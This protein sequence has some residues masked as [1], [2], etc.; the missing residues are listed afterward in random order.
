[1]FSR[2]SNGNAMSARGPWRSSSL[3]GQHAEVRVNSPAF[4]PALVVNPA[5]FAMVQ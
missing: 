5:S 3:A 4:I 2:S 1:M